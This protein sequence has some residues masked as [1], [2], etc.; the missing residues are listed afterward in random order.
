MLSVQSKSPLLA[1]L[2]NI[3]Q[4][5]GCTPCRQHPKHFGDSPSAIESAQC[6]GSEHRAKVRPMFES[7]IAVIPVSK[8]YLNRDLYGE[9]GGDV[10]KSQDIK[11]R[12]TKKCF[13]QKVAKKKGSTANATLSTTANGYQPFGSIPRDCNSLRIMRLI[14]A[15]NDSSPSN[16]WADSISSLNSGSSLNWNGG[17]PLRSFLC[18]DTLA[19]PIVMYI[20]VMTH[21]YHATQK[22]MPRSGGTL[23]RH[24]TTT[25]SIIIEEAVKENTTPAQGRHSL[26]LKTGNEQQSF[27]WIIAAVRRDC[28]TIKATIHHIAAPTEREARQSLVK[29][30]ICFFAG[31]INQAVSHA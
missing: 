12:S 7:Y 19:T 5:Q 26:N 2:F 22:T 21:Y 8:Q 25:D 17:L 27:I 3:P 15:A 23:A 20:C 30:H 16:C 11:K 18:V 29:D 28:P 1:G 9:A 24:L 6:G 10:L 4:S 14:Q 13:G 31:R